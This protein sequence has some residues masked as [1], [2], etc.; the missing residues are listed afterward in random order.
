MDTKI[1]IVLGSYSDVDRIKKAMDRLDAMEVP[2]EMR[3]ASA[4]R[5]PEA[6]VEWLSAAEAKGIGVIIAGAGAAA[7]LPGVVASKTLLPVIGIPLNA[8]PLA[9][10]DALYSIVQMPPGIPVATVGIDSAENAVILAMQILGVSDPAMREKLAEYRS[11]WQKKIA[12]QNEKLYAQ[13]PQARPGGED[14]KK[15]LKS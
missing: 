13:Y 15:S 9:G 10:T 14:K 2:Y 3:V 7:H 4:H 12:D 8:S 1:G 5:T 11:G 6:L